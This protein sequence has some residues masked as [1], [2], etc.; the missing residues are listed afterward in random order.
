MHLALRL[1]GRSNNDDTTVQYTSGN[2]APIELLHVHHKGEGEG[3]G[4]GEGVVEDIDLKVTCQEGPG[5]SYGHHQ[6]PGANLEDDGPEM[7]LRPGYGLKPVV[8]II[9]MIE[10]V[11]QGKNS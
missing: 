10:L 11:V 6:K 2:L 8:T 7:G 5:Y 4:E 9:I 3:D 1:F